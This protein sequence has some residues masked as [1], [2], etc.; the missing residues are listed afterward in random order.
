[1]GTSIISCHR[2]GSQPGGNSPRTQIDK[3]MTEINILKENIRRNKETIGE[4]HDEK[5]RLQRQMEALD[6]ELKSLEQQTR[7]KEGTLGA[8]E[9]TL[10]NL[11]REENLLDQ[12]AGLFVPD[13]IHSESPPP[14]AHEGNSEN[15]RAP[16]RLRSETPKVFAALKIINTLYYTY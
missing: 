7:A 9:R 2:V 6:S 16:A 10:D 12:A 13:T 5:C 14:T 1:M 3:E 4:K 11:K 15:P 8:R